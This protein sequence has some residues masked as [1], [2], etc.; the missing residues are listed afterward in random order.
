MKR[1]R[2][3][4]VVSYLLSLTSPVVMK[5]FKVELRFIAQD[6]TTEWKNV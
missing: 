2:D 4:N 6:Q 1:G 5:H 3:G